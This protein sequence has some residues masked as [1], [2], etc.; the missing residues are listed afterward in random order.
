VPR[1]LTYNVRRCVGLDGDLSPK[2]IADV[3]A[4]CTPDIVALQ[5]LDVKRAR[6]RHVDQAEEIALALEMEMHFHPAFT[7]MEEAYGDAILTALP[8][9]LVKAGALPAH[10]RFS[11][12]EPRGALWAE[13][14]IAGAALQVLNTHLGL[15]RRERLAQ[16]EMLLGPHWLGHPRAQAPLV[17][18]GDFNMLPGSRTY[19]LLSRRLNDAQRAPGLARPCATFPTRLPFARIDHVFVSEGI[20]VRRVEAPRTPLARTASDHLPLVVD[21]ELSP[22]P[23]LSSSETARSAVA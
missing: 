11:R 13:I 23:E 2:R 18:V 12:I 4:A 16:V 20:A 22:Q 14:D 3:I 21:L 19:R 5:E 8:S 7:V 9:R 15:L 6:T 10:P 17:L 1:I